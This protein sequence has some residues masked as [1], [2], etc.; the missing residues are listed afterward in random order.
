M[1]ADDT[2]LA[3][4]G[5]SSGESGESS[6]DSGDANCG[7]DN[8]D[9]GEGTESGG[10]PNS[11]MVPSDDLGELGALVRRRPV[12]RREV[13]LRPGCW[14]APT[15]DPP[16]WP[17]NGHGGNPAWPT[18]T[19]YVH[20]SAHALWHALHPH[21]H[22][23]TPAAV[24]FGGP[25]DP[26]RDR[27]ET[28]PDTAADRPAGD[29]EA[30]R[31]CSAGEPVPAAARVEGRIGP[32][33][34]D[35]VK[36]WLAHRRVVL[37]PV[38]DLNKNH[39]VDGHEVPA[40]MAE[41]LNLAQ[42]ASVWPYSAST[43]R[44]RDADHTREFAANPDGTPAEPGQ[45]RPETPAA[46]NAA[47]TG[48]RPT[49]RAGGSTSPSA[50]STCGAPRTATGTASTTPAPTASAPTPTSPNTTSMPGTSIRGTTTRRTTTRGTTTPRTSRAR[51]APHRLPDLPFGA[52]GATRG[53]GRRPVGAA[54][55]RRRQVD[56][57]PGSVLRHM[58]DLTCPDCRA[59][60]G[61]GSLTLPPRRVHASVERPPAKGPARCPKAPPDRPSPGPSEVTGRGLVKL[62]PVRTS[63]R[64]TLCA[65]P[66]ILPGRPVAG[67]WWAGVIT[68]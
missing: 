55:A 60:C 11:T 16:G 7:E 14:P 5:D 66:Q 9:V 21:A 26:D 13:V 48:S 61:P 58:S 35:Q 18:A 1:A 4:S 49:A 12:D 65:C 19:V 50:A 54:A 46:W 36:T 38:V 20:L 2:G 47:P 24:A 43:S 51:T 59:S 25:S 22:P 27:S 52:L 34:L 45:T 64:I 6:G 10:E 3:G 56:S 39:A 33:L 40:S 67:L 32:V 17:P 31:H 57:R 28:D 30:C 23:G 62:C 68:R 8:G 53:T 37:K 15:H 41:A 29:A 44:R 63:A 42:P